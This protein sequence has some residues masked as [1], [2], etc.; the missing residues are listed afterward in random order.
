MFLDGFLWVQ[1]PK[2]KEVPIDH[3][4]SLI[5]WITESRVSDN[6]VSEAAFHLL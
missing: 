2:V 1:E 5:L 6:Q 3:R 4:W